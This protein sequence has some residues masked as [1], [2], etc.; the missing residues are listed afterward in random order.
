MDNV[1]A[2]KS[3]ILLKS[4]MYVH[5]IAVNVSSGKPLGWQQPKRFYN[6]RYEDPQLRR[7]AP[8]TV[9]PT[10]YWNS[11]LIADP[12]GKTLFDFYTSE[13]KSDCTVILEGFSKEG[14]PLTVKAT[15]RR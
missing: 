10:L 11:N 1:L 5:D 15:V 2:P 4:R 3:V 12:E 8:E 9:R 6:P 7:H 13:H 14:Y